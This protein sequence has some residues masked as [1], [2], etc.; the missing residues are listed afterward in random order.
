MEITETPLRGNSKKLEMRLTN[1]YLEDVYQLQI[2]TR[3][4]CQ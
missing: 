2:E 3:R 1:V 4:Q